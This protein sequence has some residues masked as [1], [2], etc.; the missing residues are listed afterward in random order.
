M[1]SRAMDAVVSEDWRFRMV[2]LRKAT[3]PGIPQC[4]RSQNCRCL[5]SGQREAAGEQCKSYGAPNLMSLP[6][7]LHITWQDDQTL[8]IERC[9]PA[10]RLL[11]FE[12]AD[13]PGPSW[14]GFSKRP[15][16]WCL[17]AAEPLLSDR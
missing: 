11:H 3:I 9:W 10:T 4:R 12:A 5:G 15:G 14:Q 2:S 1:I 16:K 13:E 7:R 6:G 8:K 17:Q